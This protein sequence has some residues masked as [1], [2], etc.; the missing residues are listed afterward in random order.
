MWTHAS[1]SPLQR[2]AVNSHRGAKRNFFRNILNPPHHLATSPTANLEEAPVGAPPWGASPQVRALVTDANHLHLRWSEACSLPAVA[3]PAVHFQRSMR[4]A[5]ECDRWIVRR[6]EVPRCMPWPSN[7]GA[8]ISM[9]RNP[10][11]DGPRASSLLGPVPSDLC[12]H[13]CSLVAFPLPRMHRAQR[14]SLY[15]R[16]PRHRAHTLRCTGHQY[17]PSASRSRPTVM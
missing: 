8:P 3:A 7:T 13:R 6:S 2:M 14:P 9:P 12:R 17:L 16:T 4:V 15:R 5:T 11:R 10:V 1:R